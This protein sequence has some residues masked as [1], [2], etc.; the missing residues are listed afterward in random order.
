MSQPFILKYTCDSW[1]SRSKFYTIPQQYHFWFIRPIRF[2]LFFERAST[3]KAATTRDPTLAVLPL[4]E[5]FVKSF[6]YN[7]FR[8]QIYSNQNR[9]QRLHPCGMSPNFRPSTISRCSVFFLFLKFIS[10]GFPGDGKGNYDP[11]VCCFKCLLPWTHG[12]C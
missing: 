12:R 11:L 1:Y 10:S 7:L 2:P 3:T 4:L 8:I 6:L 9:D 5:L